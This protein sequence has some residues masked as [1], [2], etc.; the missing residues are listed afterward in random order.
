MQFLSLQANDGFTK[1]NTVKVTRR[2]P[3]GIW[4]IVT[5]LSQSD[6]P[7]DDVNLRLMGSLKRCRRLTVP[8]PQCH[9]SQSFLTKKSQLP[10]GVLCII[11]TSH[12]TLRSFAHILYPRK[13][14]LILPCDPS[15]MKL[16]QTTRPSSVALLL[17]LLVD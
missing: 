9:C 13:K 15:L 7:M 8:A 2:T 12:V 11:L 16:S 10:C 3:D 4:N 5:L 6:A 1:Q 17:K 14:Q